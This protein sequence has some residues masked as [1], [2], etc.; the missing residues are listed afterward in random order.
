MRVKIT[1][2]KRQT[3]TEFAE[4]NGLVLDVREIYRESDKRFHWLV[5]FEN[6]EVKEGAIL[7]GAY[8]DNYEITSSIRDYI[9]MISGQL[10]VVNAMKRSRREIRAPILV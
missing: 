3:L 2:L 6:V 8:G 9:G 10:L 7:K 5:S 4:E 1:A